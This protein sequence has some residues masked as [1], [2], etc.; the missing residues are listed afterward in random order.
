MKK[1]ILL[2]SLFLYGCFEQ[3]ESVIP[4]ITKDVVVKDFPKK[5]RNV[6]EVT[7]AENPI[8]TVASKYIGFH[9]RK[10]RRELKQFVGVD[11]VRI[12]WCAA[13]VNAVLAE[14][15]IPGSD[16]VSEWPLTARSFLRWGRRVGHPQIGDIII[17]PRGTEAWQGHVGFYYSTEYIN[18]KKYYQVLGGNQNDAVTLKLFPA[19]SAI[20]IRRHQSLTIK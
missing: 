5:D 6:V 15:G 18:G 2:L 19:W 1:F 10:Q 17:L 14:L 13:F 20:S 16:S 8:I 7:A 3:P 4:E 12:E 9:E 11:P